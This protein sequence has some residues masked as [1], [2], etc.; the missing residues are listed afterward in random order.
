VVFGGIAGHPQFA[1]EVLTRPGVGPLVD[2]MNAHAYFETWNGAPLE[3]LPSYVAAF[4]PSLGGGARP[5]WLA[6]IGYSDYR[7]GGIVSADVRARFGYEH[8]PA[9]QAVQLVRTITLALTRREVALVA[10]Y[11]IKDSRPDAAVI[12]DDNNR[13]L[14]VT[15]FDLQPKPALAALALVTRLFGEGFARLDDELRLARPPGSQAEVHAFVTAAHHALVVAWLPEGTPAAG[16]VSGQAR[17]HRV[18]RLSIALPL[19]TDGTVRVLDAEGREQPGATV[20]VHRRQDGL[21]IDDLEV[22]GGTVVIVDLP[23]R[24]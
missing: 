6:E 4:A 7:R 12:G 15:A 22:R 13:H 24:P 3:S 8:T 21:G 17:D 23:V 9:F 11:E 10:W 14:G 5:L 20:T 19:R 1:A 18:E 16:D 2:V